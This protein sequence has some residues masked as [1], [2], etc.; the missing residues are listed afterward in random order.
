MNNQQNNLTQGWAAIAQGCYQGVEWV[1][2]VRGSSRRLDNEADPLH[3]QLLRT[4]NLANSLKAVSQT[5]MTVGFFGLSQAGKSYLI[6]AL[7]AGS[8]GLL[9]SVYDGQKIDFI[10]H[11]NPVG[12]GK[13]ATGLVTRFTRHYPDAPAG[14][15]I[16]LRLFSEIDIAKILAN[17]W[18]QDFNH[19]QLTYQLDQSR[20]DAHLRPYLQQGCGG[21]AYNGVSQED[22]VALWDYLNTSFRKSVEKL[23][24]GYWPQV[25]KIAPR[26][27][28]QQRAE[29][30]SLLWGEEPALTEMYRSLASV[31]TRLNHAQLVFAPLD[32]LIDHQ[33]GSIMNVDCLNQLGSATDRRVEV[34]FTQDQQLVKGGL[35]QAELAAL[36]TELIFPLADVQLGSIVE[37]V[38]LLDFPGYRGR[39]NITSVSD[40][41]SDGQNPV[42]QLLLRGKVAYLLERYTDNQEMNALVVCASTAKQSD[43]SDVGP[44]LTRWVEKTQGHSPEARANNKPGLFWAMTMCDMRINNSLQL[45]ESQLKEG[46]EGMLHMTLLE[47]FSHYEWLQNWTANQSFNNCFLVRKPGIDTPFLTLEGE[48][49]ETLKEVG[50][51]P[52]YQDVL[53]TM[54]QTFVAAKN[55][56]RHIAD[57]KAA[58]VAMLSLN[59]GGMSRLTDSLRGVANGEFKAQRLQQQLVECR[60]ELAE[61]RLGRWYESDSANQHEKKKGVASALWQGLTSSPMSIGEMISHLGLSSEEMRDIYLSIR[62]PVDNDTA[63]GDMSTPP[64][65]G[66]QE[67]GFNPFAA[68]PFDNNPFADASPSELPAL[69]EPKSVGQDDEFA[70]QLFKNWVAYLRD[71][72]QRAL[73][74]QKMG[75]K[76][77]LIHLLTEELVTAATRMDLEA[78]LKQSLSGQ[79]QAGVARETLATR[80]V[81][82]AQCTLQDFISWFGYLTLPSD[83]VPHSY[84]G[85]KKKVFI[86]QPTIDNDDLPSLPPHAQQLG[87][88]YLTDWV[89]ALMAVVLDNAGHT[90]TRDI[91]FEQNERL[92]QII[93]NLQQ[94]NAL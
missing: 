15:P 32:S 21:G 54:G 84:M 85:D 89:C 56:N 14:Y 62:E 61:K 92:G 31:L 5:P 35:T 87:S 53:R 66:G 63:T 20:I 38:D 28:P 73:F 25:L 86:S 55:T 81:L 1:E 83:K 48:G 42:S 75:F 67:F 2:E 26:L 37:N 36:T 13:E 88:Q 64:A 29:F 23:E 27:S 51:S 18:F 40:A 39:L 58:W 93:R 44:I 33:R 71:L 59:D 82:R 47:R 8:N 41:G 80:Q 65:F 6:S 60:K 57:P 45:T 50:F 91:S 19:E 7:A 34:C 76:S 4:A 90:A 24:H 78:Q 12:G 30:F 69:A 94:E 74:W 49:G 72:P 11:V 77:E 3:I 10:K 79:E 22:V 43:V 9:E 16:P 70:H 17:T 52:R 68:N 46:W